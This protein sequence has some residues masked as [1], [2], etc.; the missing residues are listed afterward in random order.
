ML[1]LAACGTATTTSPSSFTLSG[2]TLTIYTSSPQQLAGSQPAQDV[3]NAERL[4]FQQAGDQIGAYTLRFATVSANKLSDNARAAIEDQTAI[5]YLGELTP[6]SSADSIGIT[7]AQ[8]LLQVSPTD[9]AVEL[10]TASPAD[11][12]SPDEYYESLSAYGRTFARVVPNTAVEAKAQVQEMRS[13]GVRKL[14]VANDGSPYGA[15]IALAVAQDAPPS[16]TVQSGPDSASNVT[17]AG[18]D[19]L[20]IGT[21]SQAVALGLFNNVARTNPKLKLFGS[22]TLD[23]PAFAASLTRAAQSDVY[24]SSPGFLPN[25]LSTA[26]RQQ[27][28]APFEK[29]YHHVPDPQAIFG[30][31]AMDALLAVLREAGSSIN[32]RTTVVHDF[33]SIKNR[34]S[35]LGTYSIDKQGDT[36]L[37]PFVFSRV[38]SGRLMPYRG[39]VEPG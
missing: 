11:P 39:V 14:Y 15:A 12:G 19:G 7:N 36:N 6:G 24:I 10:T 8:D 3:E 32:N 4:A 27:F 18:A 2:K 35:V 29:A 13:L 25:D 26:A 31:E 38:V 1:A 34:D 21:S 22:S 9:T 20:F 17:A 37:G 28:V 33:F 23:D 16:I 5:A 30:Y